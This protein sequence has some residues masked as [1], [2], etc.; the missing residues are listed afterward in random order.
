MRL[1]L[2]TGNAHKVDEIRRLFAEAAL[3]ITVCAA[4]EIGGMPEVEES[5]DTFRGNALLKAEALYRQAPS[6]TWILADDSGLMVGALGGEPGVRSARYAGPGA[7]DADNRRKLL[8]AMNGV[9]EGR[10]QARFVCVLAL[11]GP[12]VREIFEG[13]CTGEILAFEAGEGGFGYDSLF[14]P[15]G[16]DQTFGEMEPEMKSRLSH[17][18]KALHLLI[19]WLRV[20]LS[21]EEA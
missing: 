14:R 17:R 10:R 8:H 19:E 21:R 9:E 12:E 7:T 3:P 6:G 16:F 5:A 18:G 13:D 1:Y 11:L 15:T 20:Y 2:A 4:D